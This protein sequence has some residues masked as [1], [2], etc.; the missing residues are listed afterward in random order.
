MVVSSRF[1]DATG[2]VPVLSKREAAGPIGRFHHAGLE[3]CLARRGGLLV[4]GNAPDCHRPVEDA[5]NRRAEIPRPILHLRQHGASGTP[6]AGQQIAVP[7]AAMDVEQRRA[8][9]VG[10]IGGMDRAAGH[11]P[12]QIAIHRAKGQFARFR[13]RPRAGDVIEEPS[14]LRCRKVGIEQQACA[15]RNQGLVALR[16]QSRANI[17]RAPVLPD[18]GVVDA[19]PPARSHTTVVSR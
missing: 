3:T 16:L 19:R 2:V 18:D 17:R 11:A 10:G 6:E 13:P 12:E 1:F 14:H 5:R 7:L 15:A 8:R 4:A 9:G